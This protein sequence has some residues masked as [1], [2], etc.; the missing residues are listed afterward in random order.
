MPDSFEILPDSLLRDLADNCGRGHWRSETPKPASSHLVQRSRVEN[1]R[2]VSG[3]IRDGSD[4]M[5]DERT[6]KAVWAAVCQAVDIHLEEPGIGCERERVVS[7]MKVAGR[8]DADKELVKFVI[9]RQG[10]GMRS[11]DRWMGLDA[12]REAEHGG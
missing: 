11:W 8:A 5:G 10:G 6:R 2:I 12:P 4:V 7:A 3:L 9:H 1:Y